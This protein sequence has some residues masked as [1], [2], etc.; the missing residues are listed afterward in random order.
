M[1]GWQEELAE[2]LR[3]LRVTQEE[4]QANLR[5]KSR[6][7]DSDASWRLRPGKSLNPLT[8][9]LFSDDI[10]YDDSEPW[11]TDLAS[12]RREVDSIVRQ[13]VRLMQRGDL[14]QTLK[15]DVLEI[16]RVLRRRSAP[17]QQPEPGNEAGLDLETISAM[18]RFCR[19]VLC[20]SETAIEDF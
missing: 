8:G 7:M 14:D 20:L 9:A 17:V 2:L 12:M 5:S 10:D 16:L 19:V 6:P 11:L 3:E 13:V 1:A 18:L 15:E 4:P